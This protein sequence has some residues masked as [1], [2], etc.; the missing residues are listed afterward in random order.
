[1]PVCFTGNCFFMDV[2]GDSFMDAIFNVNSNTEAG[3]RIAINDGTGASL[4]A[5]QWMLL[6]QQ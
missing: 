4:Y 3:K 6:A 5:Q 2:D 1:M